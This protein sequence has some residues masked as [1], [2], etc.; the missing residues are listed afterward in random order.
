MRAAS[1]ITE[2]WLM[3]SVFMAYDFYLPTL[4]MVMGEGSAGSSAVGDELR[5]VKRLA[6]CVAENVDGLRDVVREVTGVVSRVVDEG[7]DVWVVL[8]GFTRRLERAYGRQTG[9]AEDKTTGI[10][11]V[12]ADLGI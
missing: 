2:D 12:F 3:R 7:G 9:E 4:W 6:F 1:E 5:E 8:D 11:L 10:D